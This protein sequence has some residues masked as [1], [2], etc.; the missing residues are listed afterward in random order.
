[1]RALKSYVVCDLLGITKETLRYWRINLDP[2]RYRSEYDGSSILAYRII[3]TCVNKQ[4]IAVKEMKVNGID[5]LFETCKL[6]RSV[7]KTKLIA[8]HYSTN[9]LAIYDAKNNNIDPYSTDIRAFSIRDI[10]ENHTDAMFSLG[11]EPPKITNINKAK[12]A[13]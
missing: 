6:H 12:S 1:M 7:L 13:V 2:N 8:F 11:E 10:V 3:E 9:T 5:I 4:G